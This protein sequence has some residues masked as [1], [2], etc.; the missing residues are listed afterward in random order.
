M[1]STSSDSL[2]PSLPHRLQQRIDH[3][4]DTFTSSRLNSRKKRK[5]DSDSH[6]DSGGGFLVDPSSS[7]GGGGFLLDDS[8]VSS[9]AGGGF[10]LDGAFEEPVDDAIPMSSVPKALRILD[11]PPD[12]DEILSVFR[13]AASGWG[14]SSRLD[15]GGEGLVSKDDWRSVCAVLLEHQAEELE[16][17][18]EE[19]AQDGYMDDPY[20]SSDSQDLG[21]DEEYQDISLSNSK[22]KRKGKGKQKRTPRN[23]SQSQSSD[24]SVEPDLTSKKLTSRQK[25]TCL[26]TFLLFFQSESPTPPT[27]QNRIMIKDIQRVS[28][29]LGEK[30]KADEVHKASPLSFFQLK[31]RSL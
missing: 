2:F 17:D 11:L 22:Q 26:D 13:N 25:Q 29:I 16:D 21:S 10:V 15:A 23:R 9:T 24:A 19:E 20:T 3:A 14:S 31:S 27:A 6:I 8:D 30:L 5:I 12:D 4:F 18:E 1:A 28:K 7:N